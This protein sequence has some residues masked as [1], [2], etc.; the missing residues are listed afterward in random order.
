MG[1]LEWEGLAVVA[2]LEYNQR[3]MDYEHNKS[4]IKV[5]CKSPDSAIKSI[6]DPAIFVAGLTRRLR[7]RLG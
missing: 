6:I 5:S 1:R 3:T 7:S 4:D 2:A